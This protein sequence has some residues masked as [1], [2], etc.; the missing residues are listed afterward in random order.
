[1][2]LNYK[3]MLL[4]LFSLNVFAMEDNKIVKK[5]KTENLYFG[6]INITDLPEEILMRILIS[7]AEKGN[8][9]NPDAIDRLNN[10]FINAK[11]FPLVN[12]R[13]YN[14]YSNYLNILFKNFREAKEQYR[15]KYLIKAEQKNALIL[16][17]YLLKKKI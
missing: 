6:K 1:M 3:I 12:K 7:F 11:N 14:L 4:S 5:R 2:K 16:I 17:K 13:F 9:E 10:F 8:G 15:Y